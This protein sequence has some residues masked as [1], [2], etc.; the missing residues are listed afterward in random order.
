MVAEIKEKEIMTLP[1]LKKK[2]STKWFRYVITGENNLIDP[3]KNMCYVAFTA[4]TEE[5]LYKHPNPFR[6]EYSSGI[7]CG[8]NVSF[9]P[10]VGGIYAHG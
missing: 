1:E 4:D 3:Y 9:A 7:D 10:E 6:G 8:Y 5:E 2:Y